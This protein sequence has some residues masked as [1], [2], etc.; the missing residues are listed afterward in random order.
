MRRR[1]I[2]RRNSIL[3]P[4]PETRQKGD[5]IFRLG[6]FTLAAITL[7]AIGYFLFYSD[8]FVVKEIV[9][10]GTEGISRDAVK[11]IADDTMKKDHFFLFPEKH[12]LAISK[13][14]VRKNIENSF[15]ALQDV[16]VEK[17]LPNS[18]KIVIQERT[19]VAVWYEGST[20]FFVDSKGTVLGKVA[21]K[22]I[23]ADLPQ[24][25]NSAKSEKAPE[26]GDYI[27]H[28]QA[29]ERIITARQVLP[30][31]IGVTAQKVTMPTG[32]ALEFTVTT[33]EGWYV[34]FDRE[35]SIQSQVE[36]MQTMLQEE[37]GD[38]R[39]FLQYIDLRV[40]NVG[41]FR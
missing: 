16:R 3:F 23:N 2:N 27:V 28:P 13:A 33:S 19:P 25:L 34:T 24:I 14:N 17:N 26:S 9:V 7:V 41:Y 30:T 4:T 22:D 21:K 11:S 6:F 8:Y 37:I 38:K 15:P 39:P 18:L 29:L 1:R 10:V 32:F 40:K 5:K 12:I 35:R 20:S 36:T 31:K